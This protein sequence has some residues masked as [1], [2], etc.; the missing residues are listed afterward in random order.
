MF[1][2]KCGSYYDENRE[3]T[4]NINVNC[5]LVIPAVMMFSSYEA[6]AQTEKQPIPD[7]QNSK[8]C[9]GSLQPSLKGPTYLYSRM[10]GF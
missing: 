10:Q 7:F 5:F 2:Q 6:S 3:Y 8:C 4:L 1:C 9:S